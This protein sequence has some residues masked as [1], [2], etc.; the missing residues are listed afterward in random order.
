MSD[1]INSLYGLKKPEEFA[2]WLWNSLAELYMSNGIA[3][4]NIANRESSLYLFTSGDGL[5]STL[6]AIVKI[7]NENVPKESQ[8][9]FRQSIGIALHKC[10]ETQDPRVFEIVNDLTHLISRTKATEALD[11]VLETAS[12]KY[13]AE[14]SEIF[15]NIFGFL[16]LLTPDEK[17]FDFTHSLV[18]SPFFD[19]RYIFGAIETMIDCKPNDAL[20]IIDEFGDRIKR[21]Y[22]KVKGLEEESTYWE[23]VNRHLANYPAVKKRIL[24][25]SGQK[26]I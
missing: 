6:E 23:A 3:E 25:F 17:V 2:D 4:G 11:S 22:G 7:Y 10:T 16:P 14:N 9:S 13:I 21:L 5:E 26:T 8:G 24:F 20:K 18:N 12:N 15:Y 19:N 1:L